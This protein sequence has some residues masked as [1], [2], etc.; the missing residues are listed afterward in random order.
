MMELLR[1]VIVARHKDTRHLLRLQYNG[2]RFGLEVLGH[3]HHPHSR[4][5]WL[6]HNVVHQRCALDTHVGLRLPR[7]PISPS[8]RGTSQAA[9]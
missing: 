8:L 7:G 6:T 5:T 1:C 3:Q 4:Q 9:G 2:F